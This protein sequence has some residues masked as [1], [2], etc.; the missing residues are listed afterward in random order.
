MNNKTK[1]I[2]VSLICFPLTVF[3]ACGQSIS[4]FD[5]TTVS[6]TDVSLTYAQSEGYSF[7][8]TIGTIKNASESLI[9]NLV[10]EVKYF[11][12][13]KKLIDVVTQPVY[14]LVVPASQEVAFRIRDVA[15]KPKAA[16]ASNAVRVVSAEPRVTRQPQPKQSSFSW[17][18][19]VLVSWVPILL[20]IAVWIYFM[21]RKDSPQ[22]R[23]I[24]LIE[25]QNAIL[26]RLAVAVEK[27]RPNES[28]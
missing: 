16:Y 14:G 9:E 25:K 20:L 11:D 12:A 26:E 1:L 28:S 6:I 19:D 22:A 8:T 21:R 5:S 24:E 3:A 4:S 10:I 13:D 7:V 15:D 17:I 23:T 2:L 27:A 18:V